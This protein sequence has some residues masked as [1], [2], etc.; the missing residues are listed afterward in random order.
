M[1]IIALLQVTILQRSLKQIQVFDGIWIHDIRGMYDVVATELNFNY[2]VN[3]FV[4][5]KF[6]VWDL[7]FVF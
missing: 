7:D 6:N 2:G 3:Y 1:F 4:S 5:C